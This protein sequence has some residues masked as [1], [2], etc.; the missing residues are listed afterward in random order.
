MSVY[1]LPTGRFGF[2]R[3]RPSNSTTN[4]AHGGLLR[5]PLPYYQSPHKS[6]TQAVCGGLRSTPA[7]KR[8]PPTLRRGVRLLVGYQ[9][10]WAG[11]P[12]K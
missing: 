7:P 2:R 6:H 3:Y 4:G 5:S 9:P 10:T 1:S 12:P 8:K 11:M